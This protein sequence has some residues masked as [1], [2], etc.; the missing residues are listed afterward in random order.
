MP[1]ERHSAAFL[2]HAE[3]TGVTEWE[4]YMGMAVSVPRQVPGLG[5]LAIN[6]KVV[7]DGLV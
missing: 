7:F 5:R 1:P 4:Y 3:W 2:T 6:L